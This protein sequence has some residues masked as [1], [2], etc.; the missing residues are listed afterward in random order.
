MNSKFTVCPESM[1]IILHI[2]ACFLLLYFSVFYLN[3]MESDGPV[4]G[5]FFLYQLVGALPKVLFFYINA[6]LLLRNMLLQSHFKIY[7]LSIFAGIVVAT[8]LSLSIDS[9]Y[10]TQVL[11]LASW[12]WTSSIVNSG[13]ALVYIAALSLIYGLAMVWWEER[14]TAGNRMRTVN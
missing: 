8:G 14:E 10:Y 7:G 2:A 1:K 4:K 3:D 13:L 12:E 5:S 9:Y 6:V 11:H